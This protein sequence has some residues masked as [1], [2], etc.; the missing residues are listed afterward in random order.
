MHRTAVCVCV[1]VCNC[2][3]RGVTCALQIITCA[4]SSHG[5]LESLNWFGVWHRFQAVE[6]SDAITARARLVRLGIARLRRH[7]HQQNATRSPGSGLVL[8]SN[9]KF[10]SSWNAAD[11]QQ[12]YIW[13][14]FIYMVV[15][16]KLNVQFPKV[17]VE[18]RRWCRFDSTTW[19]LRASIE[20]R[21]WRTLRQFGLFKST[22]VKFWKELN[23]E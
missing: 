10:G 15:F 17:C 1:C 6:Q 19:N 4:F 23:R 12:V 9:R 13:S 14:S 22:Q 2:V 18:T 20:A 16:I 21:R 7:A 5:V 11:C 3:I 8:R